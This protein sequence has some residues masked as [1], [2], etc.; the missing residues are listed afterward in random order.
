M[1]YFHRGLL[2][3]LILIASARTNPARA[4]DIAGLQQMYGGA[5][6]P[7]VSI[8]MLSHSDKLLPLRTVHRGGSVQPLPRS[9]KP[10]PNLHFSDRRFMRMSSSARESMLT[11][12]SNVGALFGRLRDL[13]FSRG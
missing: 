8:T 12:G 1:I 10:F 2:P 4:S 3:A 7:D 11:V 13:A 5:V 6:L 9:T